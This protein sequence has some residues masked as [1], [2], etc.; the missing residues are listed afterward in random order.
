MRI[1]LVTA[2]TDTRG[3]IADTLSLATALVRAGARVTVWSLGSAGS[4][5]AV[6]P[7][8]RLRVVP[9]PDVPGEDAGALAR[10]SVAA[11]GTAIAAAGEEYDVVHAQD[12]VGADAVPG[13][14]RT[15]HTL[16]ASAPGVPPRALF[17]TSATVAAEVRAAWGRE[18]TVVPDGVD[19]DQFAAAGGPEGAAGR[20][21]WRARLGRYVLAVGRPEPRA[22]LLDLV[23]A[24]ATVQLVHPD[25]TLVVAGGQAPADPGAARA[26]LDARAQELEV[27]PL[28]LDAV[29]GDERATLVA[30]ADVVVLPS[31]REGSGAAGLEA[32]A[33]GVPVVARDRPLVREVL[34]DAATFAGSAARLAAAVLAAAD[35][36]PARVAAGRVRA[37]RHSWADVARAHLR[38]YEAL[39]AEARQAAAV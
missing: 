36:D 30:A 2:G 28:L 21:R 38:C 32:L 3:G 20:G 27:Y 17:C 8:V 31:A 19:G 13:C 39:V 23:E 24:M 14:V 10:R 37:A 25:V 33:A 29:P 26:V 7:A 11:L 34:G 16:D 1:A 22:G 18:A 9:L 15:V 5:A 4:A 12:R 35:P 6:D